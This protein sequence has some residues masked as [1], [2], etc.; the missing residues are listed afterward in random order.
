MVRFDQNKSGWRGFFLLCH[1]LLFWLKELFFCGILTKEN[2]KMEEI[3]SKSTNENRIIANLEYIGLDLNKMPTFLTKQKKLEYQPRKSMEDNN[4][5]VY[6][7]IPIS[8]IQILLTP[9]NRLNT[10]QEKF[11]KASSISDYL[12]SKTEG[13]ILRHTTFLKMLSQMEITK[14]EE[15]E[16]EQKKLQTKEPFLVKYQ[17]NYL[18]Q[19]Y[20]SDIADTYFMLVPTED[21]DYS[22]FFY[23]LKKQLEIKKTKKEEYIFV[24]ISY[25]EYSREYLK[26][27]QIED[28]EKYMWQ[29]TKNWITTYEVYDKEENMS[30]HMI[31]KMTVYEKIESEYKVIFKT[32]ED[33]EKFYKFI[34]ALF[35]LETELPHH[36]TFKTKINAKGILEFEYQ[37]RKITYDKLTE[38]LTKEY[39]H[40]K[41]DRE[42]LQK[43]Q[44]TLETSFVDSKKE[45]YQKEQEYFEKERMIATYLE[46]RKT[47]F[48]KVRYFWKA[49]KA[50]KWQ[51]KIKNETEEK[52]EEKKK[53]P[54]E[55]IKFDQ[56]EYY[57]IED[58][59][60]IYK[61]FDE[62]LQKIKSLE[63]DI[64]AQNQKIKSLGKKI[65]N[66]NL[67]LSEI[68]KHEKSI[69]EFWRFAN[70][71][72]QALLQ[73]PE[74]EDKN[75]SKF[76][77]IF[78]YEE[79][80]EEMAVL[81]DKTQRKQL[82][83]GQTDTIFIAQT[84]LLSLLKGEKKKEDFEESLQKLKEEAKKERILFNQENFD[85]FGNVSEDRTKVQMLA[86]KKHREVKKD[87]FKILDITKNVTLEEYKEKILTIL[88]QIQEM[89]KEASSPV[90]IPLYCVQEELNQENMQI[91][92]IKPE[93]AIKQEGETKEI[94]LYRINVKRQMPV[95]YFTNSMYYDNDNKTL[96]FGMNITSKCL[97]NLKDYEIMLKQKEKFR[98]L[99]VEEETKVATTKVNMY[100]Y[101]IK[102]N[103]DK[104][105]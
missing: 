45:A 75:I 39:E 68:D 33:A 52:Q 37:E 21:L 53:E 99:K 36:Y 28:L 2:E 104:T 79:D 49:K 23:L 16:K 1:L 81:I 65:E 41:K 42:E 98:I 47:F 97:V 40:A 60:Q 8:K 84:E 44:A 93:E 18:W 13:N 87:K 24:P 20:Y 70:K 88:K 80:F 35:I 71:D 86:G 83:K 31:G 63:I 54:I 5:K 82:T 12:D 101:E 89:M 29:L 73:A 72:E 4:Y 69:F 95:I 66:A 26:K 38:L 96:P 64:K 62:K 61:A 17:R 77:K 7:Y 9:C 32:K 74:E 102:E 43:K 3:M 22:A 92:Y 30:L 59:L 58:I 105:E 10:I 78:D 50:K 25:E 27:S 48:G 51:N 91:F 85:L 103:K 34:K 56:K 90:S 76:E 19:I 100:E 67:Y 94:N 46:C 57:T 6:R 11:S 15:I 55:T 14:I